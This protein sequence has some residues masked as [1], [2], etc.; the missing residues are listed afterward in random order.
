MMG[1]AFRYGALVVFIA[2][3]AAPAIAAE[4]AVTQPESHGTTQ[5]VMFKEL[6]KIVRINGIL[7]AILYTV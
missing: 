5:Q 4:V 6:P 7:K 1:V 2:G 3:V